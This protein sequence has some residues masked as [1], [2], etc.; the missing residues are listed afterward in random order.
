MEI[1]ELYNSL[2]EVL[3]EL[4]SALDSLSDSTSVGKRKLTN[5]LIEK[6]ESSWSEAVSKTVTFVKAQ[7]IEVQTAVVQ[8]FYQN[9][10]KNFDKEINGYL[11]GLVEAQP[12]QKPLISE[13][14]VEEYSTKR[15]EVYKKIKAIVELGESVGEEGMEMPRQRKGSTGKRGPRN[16]SLFVFWIDD[17]E[18]DMTIGQ[19]AKENGYEKA[20][21]LTKA[22]RESGFDT[23]EGSSFANFELP[24][25][26]ILSGER[27]DSDEEEEEDEVSPEK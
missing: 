16:L 8:A 11:E 13:D 27:D 12:V 18:V 22:L 14:Q 24:N 5:E 23:K 20:A 10:R 9:L 25:G 6:H 15:K 21:D 7:P 19:I 2:S 26:K 4:D 1:R 17:E 3:D